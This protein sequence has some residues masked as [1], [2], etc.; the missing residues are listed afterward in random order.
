MGETR[1]GE[2]CSCGSGLPFRRCH[3]SVMNNAGEIP[4]G[5]GDPNAPEER[6]SLVGFP[7][8]YQTLHMMY[9]F[10]GNDPRNALPLGGT[11]GLYEV[12]FILHRP[13]YKLQGEHNFSFSSGLRGDSH[14]AI[15]KPAYAP[16]GNPDADQ[17][18]IAGNTEDGN[19]QFTGF[20]N[21]KGHLGKLVTAPFQAK[22]RAHAEE[23]AYRAIASSLSNM[24]LHLDIPLDIGVRETKELSNGSTSISLMSPYLE[25]PM[26]IHAMANFGP[27]FRSYA[28]LYREALNTDTPVFQFLCLFKI[29]EALRARRT[30]LVREAKKT[31]G[32][33]T[34]PI[35]QMPHNEAEVRVWTSLLR[36]VAEDRRAADREETY[37]LQTKSIVRE[38]VRSQTLIVVVNACQGLGRYA[39]LFMRLVQRGENGIY[40]SIRPPLSIIRTRTCRMRHSS[41][42]CVRL[43]SRS[44]LSPIII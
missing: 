6:V 21:E 16:P 41:K 2:L 13:G 40:I 12:T 28:A 44:S 9:R 37:S 33:Y 17:I 8:T 14:L 5:K 34:V 22:D 38:L 30:R 35:E 32:T 27:E 29:I 10:K 19:F 25:A 42:D 39:W 23:I 24:S 26:A 11:P 20:P 1:A 18:L 3:G 43:R 15:S 31:G 36:W 7:G 4:L